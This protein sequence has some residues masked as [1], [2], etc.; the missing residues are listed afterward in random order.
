MGSWLSCSNCLCEYVRGHE[1]HSVWLCDQEGWYVTVETTLYMLGFWVLTPSTLSL[2]L[3][4]DTKV[5]SLFHWQQTKTTSPGK[6]EFIDCVTQQSSLDWS[7]STQFICK[8]MM[9]MSAI[10]WQ[11]WL[12]SGREKF[13]GLVLHESINTAIHIQKKMR[14][15]EQTTKLKKKKK[16]P[17]YDRSTNE[18]WRTMTLQL[19]ILFSHCLTRGTQVLSSFISLSYICAGMRAVLLILLQWFYSV[20]LKQS[21]WFWGSCLFLYNNLIFYCIKTWCFCSVFNING[22]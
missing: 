2:Q 5:S 16:Q 22:T 19:H 10:T 4:Q 6:V 15:R 12:A 20:T 18:D 9:R 14:D 7:A 3:K 21:V 17:R 11:I 8:P 1:A 13:P